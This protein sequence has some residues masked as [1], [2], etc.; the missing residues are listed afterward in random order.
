MYSKGEFPTI[1]KFSFGDIKAVVTLG[2]FANHS[3]GLD[4]LVLRVMILYFL[5][6]FIV[7]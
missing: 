1:F 2:L 5:Y 3:Y 6:I 4:E 7:F